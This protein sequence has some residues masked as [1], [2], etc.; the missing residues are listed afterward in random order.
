MIQNEVG[1]K[2]MSTAKKKSYLWWLVNRTY[3]V[4][5]VKM[6]PAKCFSPAPKV[7]SCLVRFIK[8]DSPE[9]VEQKKLENF[10][11]LYSPYSRKTL[12]RIEKMLEKKG[13]N[14][15]NIPDDLKWKRLEELNR[16]NIN[17]ILS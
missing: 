6:V 13:N 16:N 17:I 2:I 8:K 12:W 14:E 4:D 10:L 7:K 1:E 5:Y 9:N 11:N 3:V 15:Y